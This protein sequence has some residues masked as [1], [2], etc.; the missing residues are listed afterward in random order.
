MNCCFPGNQWCL[1]GADPNVS[2]GCVAISLSKNG[3][4]S[5]LFWFYNDHP[6]PDEGN[7]PYPRF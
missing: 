3:V 1:V 4:K 2:K 5:P 6:V 7:A